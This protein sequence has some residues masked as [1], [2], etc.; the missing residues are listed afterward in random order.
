MSLTGFARIG[1]PGFTTPEYD[2][3]EDNA[4]SHSL[5]FPDSAIWGHPRYRWSVG[6]IPMHVLDLLLIIIP[7]IA[8]NFCGA[9]IRG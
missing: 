1:C 3:K 6:L 5:F 9:N 2:P 7:Y 8:G 4:V